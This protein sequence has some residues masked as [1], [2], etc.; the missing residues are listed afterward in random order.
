[1][2]EKQQN[3][4]LPYTD[5]RLGEIETGRLCFALFSFLFFTGE[6]SFLAAS[7]LFFFQIIIPR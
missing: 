6:S 7:F 5:E 2:E 4:T 1:M 3:G